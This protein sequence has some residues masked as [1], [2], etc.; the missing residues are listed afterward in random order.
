MSKKNQ[1]VQLA[2]L[3]T[4]AL[5]LL[6]GYSVAI[7]EIKKLSATHKAENDRIRANIETLKKEAADGK[8]LQT[9]TTDREEEI[10]SLIET[11]TLQIMRNDAQFQS[12]KKPYVKAKNAA[13]AMIPEDVYRSYT[14][15]WEDG[16]DA[17]WVADIKKFLEATGVDVGNEV[18]V[19]NFAAVMKIRCAGSRNASAKDTSGRLLAVK[20]QRTFDETVMKCFID[21]AVVEKGVL[22][23][24]EDG[25]ITRHIFEEKQ[26]ESE[27]K[28]T[29]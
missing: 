16:K 8:K 25:T 4:E 13:L 18:A 3:S 21:Y 28:Q 2:N 5:A 22:D 19:A 24:A 11:L 26:T 27:E 23:R 12:D 14:R 6:S 20:G 7:T 10:Q 29:A 1:K 9:L 17:L 15:A